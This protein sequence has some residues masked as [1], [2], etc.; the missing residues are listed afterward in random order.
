MS[1]RRDKPLDIYK[2]LQVVR[3]FDELIYDEDA[4][5]FEKS[6]AMESDYFKA[7]SNNFF[8]YF[9]YELC[10]VCDVLFHYKTSV[11]KKKLNIPVTEVGKN[12]KHGD[13]N[14]LP[15]FIL[16]TSYVRHIKSMG[17]EAD[18]TMDYCIEDDDLV[19]LLLSTELLC[20]YH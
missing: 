17:D 5:T 9:V 12:D 13:D 6:K 14:V 1:R 4:G 7:V 3:S 16:P 20:I 10:D 2:R 18:M 8:N 15:D 19:C 11:V